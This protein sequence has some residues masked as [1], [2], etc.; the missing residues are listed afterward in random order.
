[1]VPREGTRVGWSPQEGQWGR[2]LVERSWESGRP[3][4]WRAR[5]VAGRRGGA[6]G[7]CWAVCAEPMNK[8][9][10]RFPRG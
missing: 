5:Q 10:P 3:R 8:R 7:R 4:L 6:A 9:I 1:M 2:G